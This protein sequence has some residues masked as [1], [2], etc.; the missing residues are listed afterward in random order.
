MCFV[1]LH[2]IFECEVNNMV[3][4]PLAQLVEHRYKNKEVADSVSG[5][6]DSNEVD[7]G[8]CKAVIS[9]H[10]CANSISVLLSGV[11]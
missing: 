1:V 9:A 10:L 3:S 11:F 7:F 4:A 5:E 2:V 6:I 8:L